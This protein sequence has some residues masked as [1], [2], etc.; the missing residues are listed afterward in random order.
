[1]KKVIKNLDRQIRTETLRCD[2]IT[3]KIQMLMEVQ[4]GILKFRMSLMTKRERELKAIQLEAVRLRGDLDPI[5]LGEVL[6]SY[7]K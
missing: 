5:E 3:D 6:N 4:D 1:M 7:L 2:K